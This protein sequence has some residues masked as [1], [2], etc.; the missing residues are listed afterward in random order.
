MHLHKSTT[1]LVWI[2]C[3]LNTWHIIS[4]TTAVETDRMFLCYK[5]PHPF[6]ASGICQNGSV[7]EKVNSDTLYQN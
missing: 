7:W 5:N 3:H 2:E 1:E 6:E 4:N